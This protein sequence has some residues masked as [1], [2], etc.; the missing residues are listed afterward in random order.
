MFPEKYYLIS[1]YQSMELLGVKGLFTNLRVERESLPEGFY[2]YSL[3]EGDEDPF[4]SVKDD[5]FVNHMG[6]F[7]CKEELDLNGQDEYDLFGDYSFT[8]DEVDLDAF[9]GEDIKAKIAEELDEF[10]FDLDT[11]DYQDNLSPGVTRADMV[12]EIRKNL[13]DK[14]K[15]EGIINFFKELLENNTEEKF[16]TDY[17]EQKVRSFISVLTEINANNHDALDLIVEMASDIR[18]KQARGDQDKMPEIQQ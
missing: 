6:D 16:L 18:E 15:V 9:F 10:Y 13:S 8:D 5:V 14:P 11:Y 12:E 7:I 17:T 1:D 3:R 2:K 4:S